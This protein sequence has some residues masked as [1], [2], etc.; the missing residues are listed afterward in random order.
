MLF[1]PVVEMVDMLD[2]DGESEVFAVRKEGDEM[3]LRL[4]PGPGE[5]RRGVRYWD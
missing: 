1:V 2:R 3:V 4:E 5:G